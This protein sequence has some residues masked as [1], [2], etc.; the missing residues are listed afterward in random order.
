MSAEV[1][2]LRVPREIVNADSVY[3][4]AWS[5]ADGAQVEAGAAVCEIETSKAI[6]E[7]EAQR[8]GYVRHRAVVGDEVSVG[9]IL[10]YITERPDTPL[11]EERETSRES[12]LALDTQISA[13]ARQKMEELGLDPSQFSGRGIVR[14]RDVVELAER[15]Q[16]ATAS[17]PRGPYRLEPLGTI[18]RRVAR[19]MEQSVAAMPA[20]SLERIIDIAPV[21]ERARSL[22]R[23]TKGVI[24][25]V[26]LLVAA[27]AR[28]CTA[29][30]RF[31]GFVTPDHQ[32]RLFEN[33]NIAV[34]VDVEGDLYVVTVMDAGNKSAAE[35]AKELRGLQYLAARRRLSAAQVAGGTITVTSMLG[36]GVH[37][38]Q[39]IPYPHQAA[40]VG[41]SDCEPGTSRC[42]LT[43]VFDHRVANGSQAAAFLV[44]IDTHLRQ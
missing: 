19:V 22:A 6:E 42:V 41:L 44:A 25:E 10:G 21:R 15:L 4:V 5:V 26:D 23:E 30:P 14:E 17:D 29:F 8:G 38:F 3:L 7:V 35:I 28:A 27:V 33:A 20:A 24:T 39:P 43:L 40:I 9:G 16:A 1:E 12:G 32:L 31:N 37:R 34:A 13:K 2:P 11:P 36:R 18:Q